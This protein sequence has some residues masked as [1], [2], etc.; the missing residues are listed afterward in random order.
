MRLHTIVLFILTS[1]IINR[2]NADCT[3]SPGTSFTTGKVGEMRFSTGSLVINKLMY[4]DGTVWQDFPGS[5]TASSCSTNGLITLSGSEPAYCN[6]NKFW[7]LDSGSTTNGACSGAGTIRWNSGVEFCNGTSWRTVTA[8]TSPDAFTFPSNTSADL[9]LRWEQTLQITGFSGGTANL[10]FS[11]IGCPSRGARVCTDSGCTS[12]LYTLANDGSFLV[13]NAAYLR[14]SIIAS[15]DVSTTCSITATIGD[16]T[17]T[18]TVGTVASDTTV[19]YSAS[20]N[21][22]RNAAASTIFMSNIVKTTSHSAVTASISG[23][24]SPEYR[25]CADASCTTMILPWGSTSRTISNNEYIQLRASSGT[26]NTSLS[27]IT[28]AAGTAGSNPRW[29]IMTSDCPLTTTLAPLATLTCYCPANYL[30]IQKGVIG[31]G[32]YRQTSDVCAAAIHRGAVT[33]ASGGQITLIGTSAGT[34]S[35][36]CP[37]FTGSNVNGVSAGSGSSGTSMYFSGYG[38][39][40]CN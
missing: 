24:G 22:V 3:N 35:G 32:N 23:P 28:F 16:K 11:A 14:L 39:D 6:V 29:N 38:T 15:S 8:D 36:T 20:F 7:S 40:I 18:M 13:P 33:N 27:T 10:T 12:T 30:N 26:G 21:D 34:P 2:V 9:D 1:L 4:C 25:S 37:S 19:I 17:S 31:N 5:P